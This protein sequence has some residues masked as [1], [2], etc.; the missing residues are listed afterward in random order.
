MVI[1]YENH[2]PKVLSKSA[3]DV[4]GDLLAKQAMELLNFGSGLYPGD[5]HQKAPN[6]EWFLVYQVSD[7]EHTVMD[8][9]DR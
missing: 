8:R 7:F 2:S 6:P 1:D 4:M 3:K 5:D 9:E